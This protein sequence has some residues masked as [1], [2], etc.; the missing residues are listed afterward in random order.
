MNE[1]SLGSNIQKL[2]GSCDIISERDLLQI[3]RNRSYCAISWSQLKYIIIKLS[4]S[5]EDHTNS[6]LRHFYYIAQD[7]G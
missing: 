1:R 4:S 7:I 2:Q 6:L 5:N 3:R